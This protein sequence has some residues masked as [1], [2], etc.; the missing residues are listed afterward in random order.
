LKNKDFI[1]AR[2]N[3]SKSPMEK[4]KKDKSRCIKIGM[5]NSVSLKKFYRTSTGIKLKKRK[6][7]YNNQR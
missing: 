7:H 3:I 6:F 2:K 1:K 5:K 4:N